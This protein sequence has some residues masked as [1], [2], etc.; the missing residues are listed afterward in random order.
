MGCLFHLNCNKLNKTSS[1]SSLK[2][3]DL[4]TLLRCRSKFDID[5]FIIIRVN[6]VGIVGLFKD[7][8][9]FWGGLLDTGVYYKGASNTNFVPQ[10]GA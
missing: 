4:S 9:D 8:G 6:N 1:S 3:G 7:Y 5:V 2:V 10:R